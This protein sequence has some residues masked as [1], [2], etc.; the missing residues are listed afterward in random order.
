MARNKYDIDEALDAPFNAR[1]FRRMLG[2]VRPYAG[3]V[4]ATF[5]LTV[6]AN[7]LALLGPLLLKSAID[8]MIPAGNLGG[9]ALLALAYTG[10]VAVSAVAMRF[11]MRFMVRVGQGIIHDVRLD[12]FRHLQDLPFSYFDSRPHGK[13]LVRLVNYV[14]AISDLL[15]N[16]IVNMLADLTSLLIILAYLLAVDPGLALYALAGVPLLVAGLLA[17]KGAQRRAQQQ[18]SRRLSNLNAY[19]HESIE[20]VR[21]TQAFV[22]E[23]VN[24]GVFLTLN[25]AYRRDWMRA[26]ML[27]I[28]MWP[29]IDA[30]SNSTVA[31]LYAA[32][33]LWLRPEVTVGMLV[34]F[35]GY[36]WR[37]WAP[38]N[39]LSAFYS[40]MLS[41]AAYIERIFE[42]LDEPTVIDDRP[43]AADLPRI[44]GEVAFDHV[45]FRYEEGAPVLEDLSFSVAPGETVALVGPTGA[46]KTTIVSLLSRFYDVQEGAVRIDGVDVRDVR[47]DSLRRQMGI[48]LQEPFL[49]PGTLLENIRYGRLDA[50]DEECIAAARA[51]RADEFIRRKPKGYATEVHERGAGLSAGERQ[52][53]SFARVLL[54]DP[55]IL[56]LDEATSSIDTRTEKALQEGLRALLAGRTSFVIA[57]RLSTVRHADRIL[58]IDGGG[59]RESGTHEELLALGGAYR[60]LYDSQFERLGPGATDAET[61]RRS[62][63]TLDSEGAAP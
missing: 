30:V 54:A 48:M 37:F 5:A 56:V 60:S 13:I 31:L 26:A 15:S 9:L 39:N 14:N 21:V 7:A 47:M 59:V 46:G 62:P 41:A 52:L 12:M 11:R 3:R 20:G 57:H 16:G 45:S 6:G 24:E 38:I 42:F 23:D 40:S 55:R 49:F 8:T 44:R 29:Y 2:Y 10:T 1:Q 61:A 18:L 32:G 17:L 63:A 43:G 34:A 27:S 51:V 19:T 35:V 58:Y 25:R 22:R 33:A 28:S 53:V 50:T 4:A 36:V